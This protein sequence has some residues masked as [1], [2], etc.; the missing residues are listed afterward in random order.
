M[1]PRLFREHIVQQL[2]QLHANPRLLIQLCCHVLQE[3]L[4]ARLNG[5]FGFVQPFH[6]APPHALFVPSLRKR[7]RLPVLPA[8]STF[9]HSLLRI[10]LVAPRLPQVDHPASVAKF[11]WTPL[12]PIC[13]CPLQ[14]LV[15]PLS[16]SIL[17]L[18]GQLVMNILCLHVLTILTHA[19]NLCFNTIH[20][21]ALLIMAFSVSICVTLVSAISRCS[22]RPHPLANSSVAR[23]IC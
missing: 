22:S 10:I 11:H 23:L 15:L 18:Q 21:L 7:P 9:L 12:F 4:L 6:Q 20:G 16:L 13:H 17:A 1:F 2:L 19:H 5:L 8:L 14:T 3:M